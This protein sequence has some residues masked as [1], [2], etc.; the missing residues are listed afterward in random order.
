MKKNLSV[1]VLILEIASISLMHAIKIRENSKP[2]NE[3]PVAVH[4]TVLQP[5]LN[6]TPITTA[7]FRI[8]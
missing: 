3:P 4:F 5:G 6:F 8:K 7:L 2:R 1:L